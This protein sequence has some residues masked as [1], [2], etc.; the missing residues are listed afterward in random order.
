MKEEADFTGRLRWCI[1]K[2]NLPV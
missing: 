2:S 1:S